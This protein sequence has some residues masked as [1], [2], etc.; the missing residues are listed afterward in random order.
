M[1]SAAPMSSTL[2]ILRVAPAEKLLKLSNLAAFVLTITAYTVLAQVSTFLYNP[3]IDGVTLWLGAGFSLGLLL[4]LPTRQWLWVIAAIGIGEFIRNL[5]HDAPIF[6]NLLLASA[7]CI[8]PLLGAALIRRSGNSVGALAPQSNMLRFLAYAVFAAPFVGA[9]FSALGT[10]QIDG[11]PFW[12]AWPRWFVADALGVL[13]VAPVFLARVKYYNP[14]HWPREQVIFALLLLFTC[15]LVLRNWSDFFDVILPYVFLALMLWAAL[16]FGLQ[17][18]T[19]TILLVGLAASLSMSLGYTPYHADALPQVQGVTMMQIRLI[20]ISSTALVV[21]VLTH[22]LVQGMSNEKRLL[23]QAHRDELTGLYNRAGLNFRVENST[24]RRQSDKPLFLLICDL[25]AFKPINDR[26]GHLAGDEVLIEVASR[27]RASIRD[28]DAVARIGGDEFVVLLDNSDR[29]SVAFIAG[30][31]LEQMTKPVRGSF[32]VVE[33]SMS[34]GITPWEID[35]NIESAM[36]A[37]DKALY[38]AKHEGK[39]RY[40]WAATP[41]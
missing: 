12:S 11:T 23:K 5:L 34:I 9:S 17:G 41:A 25:D 33:L 26:Y 30:R 31:I 8:E 20:V 13:V 24:Q 2:D 16:R 37:A 6:G 4:K 27:L 38:E 39:N 3:N 14:L 1:V 28:G 29:E 15:P 7:N 19:L 10:L 22:D 36:R 35:S 32:G 40:V 21:A 18:T